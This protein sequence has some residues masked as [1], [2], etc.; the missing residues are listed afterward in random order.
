[1]PE[2]DTISNWTNIVT[3]ALTIILMIIMICLTWKYVKYTLDILRESS[4]PEIIVY[5]K[6]LMSD[7]TYLYH[8]WFENVGKGTAFNISTKP[9]LMELCAENRAFVESFGKSLD[10]SDFSLSAKSKIFFPADG[11][12]IE[13]LQAICVS[14]ENIYEQE[15]GNTIKVSHNEIDNRRDE[16]DSIVETLKEIL[17]VYDG[18]RWSLETI[19]RVCIEHN[20]DKDDIKRL[21]D[22]DKGFHLVHKEQGDDRLLK[23]YEELSDYEKNMVLRKI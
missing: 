9:Q 5:V 1:M 15:F 4:R 23:I 6:R 21:R 10:S 13:N 7:D 16:Y 8:L 11:T 14:Y 20:L 3:S 22:I 12:K 2:L 18:S 19:S 17:S